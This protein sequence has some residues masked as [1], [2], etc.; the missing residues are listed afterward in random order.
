M[1]Y[2]V[3]G[4]RTERSE[5]SKKDYATVVTMTTP[6]KAADYFLPSLSSGYVVLNKYI[7]VGGKTGAY[8]LRF[9]EFEFHSPSCPHNC[10]ICGSVFTSMG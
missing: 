3:H 8:F 10:N 5:R 2:D 7:V 6:S 1:L 4:V 9:D